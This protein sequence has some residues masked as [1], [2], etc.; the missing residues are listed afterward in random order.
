MMGFL[1]SARMLYYVSRVILVEFEAQLSYYVYCKRKERSKVFL[2]PFF[3]AE[4]GGEIEEIYPLYDENKQED[5]AFMLT[6]WLT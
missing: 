6:D 4:L 1:I 2:D 3:E 5:L